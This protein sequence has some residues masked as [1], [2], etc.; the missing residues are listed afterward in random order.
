MKIPFVS[1]EPMHKEISDEIIEKFEEVY[2]RNWFIKGKELELF[3]KEFAD[4]CDA[5]YCIGCG[6]GLD[7]IY[8]ALRA[9][10]IGP[11]DEVI[12]PSHT[13]IATSLAV[14][15]TGAVPVFVETAMD[16]YNIDVNLI[17]KAITDKTRCIIP[18]H[19]YG[20]PADMDVIINIAKKYNLRVIEDCAQA[21][22]ALYKGRKVGSI[23][24]VG[25]FSFYPGKNLGA[26]GDGG[27]VITNNQELADKISAL[28]NYGSIEKYHH[29]YKGTNSRLDEVQ[30][31]FLRIKLKYIDK[32]NV[33]RVRIARKYSEGITN[34]AIIKPF[35]ADYSKHVWHLFVVRTLERD[36]FDKYLNDFGI[37]TTVHYPIP[38]YLQEA[39]KELNI[40]P[41]TYPNA[42]KIAK[43]CLSLPLWYGI[44]DAEIDYVIDKI[45]NWKGGTQ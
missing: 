43:T 7:A 4:Y 42:D 13:F 6:N 9:M 29:I 26:L 35:V 22:G 18:V 45:N 2:K 16:T 30:A 28:G 3:E 41:G 37:G 12:I 39:Y 19:L 1:F 15:Y 25:A 5:G 14:S 8:L 44:S 33:E 20:Q 36:G 27:A 40:N 10:D 24:D 17:E 32:W 23:G 34:P 38:I 31:A 21:H 11:S